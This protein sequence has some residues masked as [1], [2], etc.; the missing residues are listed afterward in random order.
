RGV[1][2]QPDLH[3]RDRRRGRGESA[4]CQESPDRYAGHEHLCRWRKV[5]AT[6]HG[7]RGRPRGRT[8]PGSAPLVFFRDV[9]D[10]AVCRCGWCRRGCGRLS[11]QD[12]VLAAALWQLRV[13]ALPWP[14]D[15]Q[16]HTAVELRRP[17]SLRS[18]GGATGGDGANHG[19]RQPWGH[20]LRVAESGIA[21]ADEDGGHVS[22][23]GR[24]AGAACTSGLKFSPYY[25]PPPPRRAGSGQEGAQILEQP[26]P[27]TTSHG[28]ALGHEHKLWCFHAER[29]P[30]ART[31]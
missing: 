25:R 15:A 11:C 22:F 20:H 5:R 7:D 1:E 6:A 28:L 17:A 12:A 8:L 4:A 10:P 2:L 18:P 29:R 19:A 16:T 31:D 27:R 3:W 9:D 21:D 13:I 23:S 14:A 26:E 24:S 30:T